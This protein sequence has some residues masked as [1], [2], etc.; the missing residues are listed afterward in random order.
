M[1]VQIAKERMKTIIRDGEIGPEQSA[2]VYLI[3]GG[4]AGL[5][6]A[7]GGAQR[8]N[9][10]RLVDKLSNASS[11]PRLSPICIVMECSVKDRMYTSTK[12]HF[13]YI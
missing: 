11:P 2:T 9:V 5:V 12:I 1:A 3:A 10:S 8:W 4:R 7:T 13:F 6:G